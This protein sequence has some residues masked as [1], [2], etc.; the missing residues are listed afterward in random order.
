MEY[1]IVQKEQRPAGDWIITAESEENGIFH[2]YFDSEPT[3]S[4]VNERAKI[5]DALLLE[6]KA[7]KAKEKEAEAARIAEEEAEE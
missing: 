4:Q 1:T 5:T 3:D 7:F 2:G 6:T